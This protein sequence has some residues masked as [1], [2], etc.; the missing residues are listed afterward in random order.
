MVAAAGS[1]APRLCPVPVVGVIGGVGSGK[2]AVAQW[3]AERH[4]VERVDAD[5]LGHLVLQN[6][7]IRAALAQ[8]FGNG[9]LTAT[10]DIDRRR[11]AELVF[12]VSTGQQ[13]ARS[14]LE[15]IVHPAI[16]AEMERK[17]A[18][19]EPGRTDAVLLDAALLLEANW[20]N[21]C[22]AIVFID[23]TPEQRAERVREQRQWSAQ[24]LADRESSQWPL[25][26]K[27]A[28]ASL[29]IDNSGP[30]EDAGNRL[31]RYLEQQVLGH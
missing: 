7:A 12:G 26:E 19:I 15:A 1:V 6:P 5:Q 16:R 14:R 28:R 3:V 27:R 10:G 30:L 20:D 17:L 25:S 11:L 24:E 22:D 18:D 13:A 23:T 4:P 31:W 9:I 21:V 8:A 29:T 2:S